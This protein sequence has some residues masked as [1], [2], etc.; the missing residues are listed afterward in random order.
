MTEPLQAGASKGQLISKDDLKTMLD[1]YYTVRG[2]DLA[3]G[4]PTKSKL[5]ELN[6]DY[7]AGDIGAK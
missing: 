5:V 3:T 4:I 2:W 1:E 7:I 6:L